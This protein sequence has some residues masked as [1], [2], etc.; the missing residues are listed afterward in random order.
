MLSIDLQQLN[1]WIETKNDF[2]LIDVREPFEHEYFNIGGQNIP[3]NEL[4]ILLPQIPK[5][6]KIVLYC[7]KGIR[8]AIALQKLELK[9]FSH[10]YN[11]SGGIHQ[12]YP[13]VNP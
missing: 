12:L 2:I 9:G 3:L 6:K 10:L 13:K 1:E 11:L 7:A 8:S 4:S 5:D